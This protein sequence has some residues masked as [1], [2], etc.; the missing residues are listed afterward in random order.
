MSPKEFFRWAEGAALCSGPLEATALH[1]HIARA[2]INT[3]PLIVVDE[4]INGNYLIWTLCARLAE[5]GLDQDWTR[6][7]NSQHRSQWVQ[8]QT[9]VQQTQG[10]DRF[11]L[12]IPLPPMVQAIFTYIDKSMAPRYLTIKSTPGGPRLGAGFLE[13]L[14]HA[15]N[16]DRSSTEVFIVTLDEEEV[17]GSTG[18]PPGP[19]PMSMFSR[20]KFWRWT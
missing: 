13:L 11:Q 16:I 1:C 4:L 9:T 20:R 18:V 12:D 7:F 15:S 10:V 2:G 6:K 8:T 14:R 3:W 19:P 5:S 17:A